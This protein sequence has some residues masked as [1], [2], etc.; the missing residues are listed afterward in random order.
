M[1]LYVLLLVVLATLAPWSCLHAQEHPLETRW[2][3]ESSPARALSGFAL[4]SSQVEAGLH[5]DTPFPLLSVF[6]LH[7]AICLLE[8]LSHKKASLDQ[9]VRIGREHLRPDT[10]S[11]MRDACKGQETMLPLREIIRYMIAESDNNACDL[12]I[13]MA[14]GLSRIQRCAEALGGGPLSLSMNENAMHTN[15]W[16]QYAN[17]STPRAVVR[18]MRGFFEAP[19]IGTVYKECLADTMRATT[20]GQQRLSAGLPR[21]ARP[22]HKTGTSD[23]SPAGV[24]FASNDVGFFELPDGTRAYLVAFIMQSLE[25][26]AATDALAAAAARA[27]YDYLTR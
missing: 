14:G 13:D 24:R 5:A 10:W 15:I 20:T 23:R 2:Q 3:Q 27:A 8:D 19:H 26:D 21:H 9:P 17:W 22:G 1:P 18:L 16:H 6:K 25:S 4:L 12:L 11:P 7:V